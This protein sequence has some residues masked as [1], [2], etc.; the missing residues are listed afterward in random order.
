MAFA[1][2]LLENTLMTGLKSLQPVSKGLAIRFVG[3]V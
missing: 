3:S 1:G 2:A